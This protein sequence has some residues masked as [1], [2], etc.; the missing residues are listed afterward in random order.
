[1]RR[2]VMFVGDADEILDPAFLLSFRER[3][4]VHYNELNSDGSGYVFVE[5][6]MRM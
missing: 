5:L 1:M 4:T 3:R 6:D 2:Y